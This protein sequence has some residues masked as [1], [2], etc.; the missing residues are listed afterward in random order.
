MTNGLLHMTLA[1]G[2]PLPED[3]GSRGISSVHIVSL[4][5]RAK[6][7][8]NED[9]DLT[10]RYLEQLSAL[11]GDETEGDGTP[12]GVMLPPRLFE[13]VLPTKGGLASWQVRRVTDYIEQRLD[14]A[15]VTED[16]ATVARLSTG[17][18]CRAFKISM[19]ETPHAYIIR[20]RIRRAQTLMLETR[21]TLSQIAYACG[22]TDQAHLTRLFRRF[23]GTTPMTWRRNWQK[24]A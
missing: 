19:G 1:S 16:L 3:I 17:H 24:V 2:S 12:D 21:N 9:L 6:R 23:I 13:G 5:A 22:L 4:L 8:L 20:Q 10:R 18:F 11:F 15:L 14:G 7:S